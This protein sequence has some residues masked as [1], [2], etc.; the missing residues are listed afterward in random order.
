MSSAQ[1]YAGEDNDAHLFLR[2]DVSP[3]KLFLQL[4]RFLLLLSRLAGLFK[5]NL[6]FLER[7]LQIRNRLLLLLK[8]FASLR[9][10][11]QANII[12]IAELR[13]LRSS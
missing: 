1:I 10:I 6:G 3:S 12:F 5:P 2:G 13:E 4:I 8:Y 9:N 11:F 7:G